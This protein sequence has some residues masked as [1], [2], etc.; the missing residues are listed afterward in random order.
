MLPGQPDVTMTL[1]FRMIVFRPFIGE[2][3]SGHVSKSTPEGVHV[4]VGELYMCMCYFT[5]QYVSNVRFTI[6]TK[7]DSHKVEFD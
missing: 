6:D 7:L 4:N 1:E 2:V 3:L 5:P